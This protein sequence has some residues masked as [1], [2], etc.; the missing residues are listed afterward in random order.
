MISKNPYLL[1][2]DTEVPTENKDKISGICFNPGVGEEERKWG[3]M[4]IKTGQVFKWSKLDI[5]STYVYQTSLST[6]VY[7]GSFT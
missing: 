1:E 2:I 7:V 3:D 4:W 6:S 5:G